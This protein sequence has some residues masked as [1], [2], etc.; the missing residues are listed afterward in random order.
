[1]SIVNL[2]VHEVQKNEGESKALLIARPDENPIDDEAEQLAAKV[3]HLFNRSGMNTGQF[4]NPEGCEDG[5]KLPALLHKHFSGESFDD[6]AAFSKACAAEY[7]RFLEP[8][9]EAEGGLLWFN[10]YELGGAHFLFIVLLKRKSG[11]TLGE[12]LSFAQVNQL[13][14][15][16]LHMAMRVNLSAYHD[17][18][19]TRY[20]AFRFGKA[21]K[22]ESEYFTHFIGCDEPKVAAKETRK[23]VEAASAFCQSQSMPSKTA[24]EFKKAVAEKCIEKAEEREPLELGDIARQIESRFSPDQAAK[25][26]EIAESDAFQVEKEIFVEKAALKKLTRASGSNR[27]L[28]LSFDT[29]LLGESIV[30]NPD[31]GELTLKELPRSLLKQLMSMESK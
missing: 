4:S 9:S 14:T 10:H 3:T 17:R 11:I 6:F 27:S 8:V 5:S 18:D 25:F 19:D 24:N 1:M 2:I 16:K 20:I 22:W 30:F 21:P 26:L 28:T 12:D 23:L 29:E 13:E 31:T 7:V 15:D